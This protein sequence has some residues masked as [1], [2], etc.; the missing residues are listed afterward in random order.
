[1]EANLGTVS[2]GKLADFIILNADPT[3]DIKNKRKIN[4]VYKAGKLVKW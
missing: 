3:K 1:M 4:A 2:K